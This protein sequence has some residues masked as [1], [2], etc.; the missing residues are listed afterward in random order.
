MNYTQYFILVSMHLLMRLNAAQLFN[1]PAGDATARE[2][3]L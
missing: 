1:D 2:L 3:R